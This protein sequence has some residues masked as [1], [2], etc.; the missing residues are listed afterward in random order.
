MRRPHSRRGKMCVGVKAR[1]RG[2]GGQKT[3]GNGGEK[4]IYV[5]RNNDATFPTVIQIRRSRATRSTHVTRLHVVF[6]RG[7]LSIFRKNSILPLPY[8]AFFTARRCP[9]N[10]LLIA[11]F[12]CQVRKKIRHHETSR[13]SYWRRRRRRHCTRAPSCD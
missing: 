2:D 10:P 5:P 11:G 1:W 8:R 12:F 3:R 4:G 7:E 9:R 6:L 13:Q